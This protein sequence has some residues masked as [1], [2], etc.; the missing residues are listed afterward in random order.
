[1]ESYSVKMDAFEGPLDLLL[2]LIGKLEIDIYDISVSIVTDQYVSYIRAMQHL[3]LDVAS[4]YLVMAATL[5]QLKSKQLLPIEQSEFEEVPD[6]DEEPTREGL[7]QQ[8]IEYKAYK[9]A[10]V[11]LKEKEEARLELFSKQPED[12][13]RY[14]DTETNDY[15]GTLSFSDLLR[16]YEKMRQRVA[17]KVRRS[18]T[19]KREER[20]LEQQ[21]VHVSEYV[22]SRERTTFF[23]FFTEQPTVEELV[24]SFLAVLELVKQRVI[25]C[26][27][28]NDDILL[29]TLAKEE[30]PIGV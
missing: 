18:K 11:V 14:L 13:L 20:T 21:M 19:V 26:E 25:A 28:M 27:Q 22:L 8:L 12:L 4:E 29:R 7:I 10:A 24:V 30:N 17:W 6:F 1:M 23:G 9:E 15:N 3:E 16:A 5:L 2:H